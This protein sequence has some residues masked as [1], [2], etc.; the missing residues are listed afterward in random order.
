MKSWKTLTALRPFTLANDVGEDR[1]S[2][3]TIFRLVSAMSSGT[4]WPIL[5]ANHFWSPSCKKKTYPVSF[6]A[7]NICSQYFYVKF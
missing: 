6:R 1:T 2:E 4:L 5:L 3:G 7:A